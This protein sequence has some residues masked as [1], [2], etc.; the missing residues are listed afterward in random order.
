MKRRVRVLSDPPKKKMMPEKDN[1]DHSLSPQEVL[2]RQQDYFTERL[3]GV[4]E[5]INKALGLPSVSP[6]SEPRRPTIMIGKSQRIK[7]LDVLKRE[8][9]HNQGFLIGVLGKLFP[10]EQNIVPTSHQRAM[11]DIE[12]YYIAKKEGINE[13][14]EEVANWTSDVQIS[15]EIVRR[16]QKKQELEELMKEVEDNERFS[17]NLLKNLLPES[18]NE[19]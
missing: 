7:S 1:S 11:G 18:P 12:G 2:A 17:V 9:I 15:G 10:Q 19:D 14:I 16:D 6:E 5:K 4:D 3:K 13:Q 8:I